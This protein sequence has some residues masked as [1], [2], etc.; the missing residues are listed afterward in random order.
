M[1]DI[2]KSDVISDDERSDSKDAD[3]DYMIYMSLWSLTSEKKDAKPAK[4][5]GGRVAPR[6]AL[7]KSTRECRKLQD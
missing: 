5:Q 2:Q 1:C 3:Y 7:Y 6:L 4:S